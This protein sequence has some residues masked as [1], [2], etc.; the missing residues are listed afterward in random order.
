M[1]LV[2]LPEKW[3]I[4][5]SLSSTE[6]PSGRALS[7]RQKRGCGFVEYF[8]GAEGKGRVGFGFFFAL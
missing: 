5:L 1:S 2:M 7:D 6:A 4:A 8:A 3:A